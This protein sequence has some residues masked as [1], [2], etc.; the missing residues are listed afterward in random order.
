MVQHVSS[1]LDKADTEVKVT[2]R[3]RE[4]IIQRGRRVK[5]GERVKKGEGNTKRERRERVKKW[6]QDK[7]RQTHAEI[8]GWPVENNK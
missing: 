3:E 2:E 4:K 7:I 8:E 1:K 6:N 5:E